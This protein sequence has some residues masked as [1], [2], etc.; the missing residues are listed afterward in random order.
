MGK[1]S[2]SL[3]KSITSPEYAQFFWNFT[4]QLLFN[5]KFVKS[6]T[7]LRTGSPYG[8]IARSIKTVLLSG[9]RN[10]KL[11]SQTDLLVD[12]SI[13]DLKILNKHRQ[14]KHLRSFCVNSPLAEPSKCA[15]LEADLLSNRLSDLLDLRLES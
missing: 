13:S 1:A 5:K 2:S 4:K 11:S 7:A 14:L 8:A 9:I 15:R 12:W 10:L 3:T 6:A